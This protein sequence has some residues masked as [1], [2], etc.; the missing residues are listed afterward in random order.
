MKLLIAYDGSTCSDL[1]LDDLQKAGLPEKGEALIMSVAEVW[2]P[3]KQ[4]LAE[5]N[6]YKQ[7]PYIE[8]II[9]KHYEKGKKA[10]AEA[11]TFAKHA[12]SKLKN[13]L[14][15]W[16][17][18]TEANYGSPGWEILDKATVFQPDLIVV[19]SHGHSIVNRLLLGSI[20]QKILSEAN[21]SVRVSRGKTTNNS[22]QKIIIG[23]DGS[24]GAKAAV[25]AVANRKWKDDAQIRLVAVTDLVVPSAIGRFI[26]PVAEWVEVEI[27]TEREWIEKMAE[28]AIQTLKNKGFLTELRILAGNPKQVLVE[29]ANRWKADTIFVGA[30]AYGSKLERFLVGS[31]ASAVASRANCSVEITRKPP[32]Q[33]LVINLS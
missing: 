22:P 24:D 14:P 21:C 33:N 7:S 6:G 11:E 5:T 20:S 4:G 9:Q 10:V 32:P 25:E 8:E 30:N 17:V 27:K 16:K 18:K 3:P 31:V 29:D 13:I 1:A 15:K 12:Q 19:G 26:P 23:F 2:L 28:S